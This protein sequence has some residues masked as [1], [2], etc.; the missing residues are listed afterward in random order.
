MTALVG[1]LTLCHWYPQL[2]T[3][4]QVLREE[5]NSLDGDLNPMNYWTGDE[6]KDLI[7]VILMPTAP[8]ITNL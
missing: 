4:F 3:L 8:E 7:N 6:L 2:S 1:T 5:L